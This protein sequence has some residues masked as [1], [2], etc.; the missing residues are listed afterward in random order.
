MV[1]SI[2]GSIEKDAEGVTDHSPG[3]RSGIA[4]P[5]HPFPEA[6]DIINASGDVE[7]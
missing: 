6:M 2:H 1:G 4:E 7:G 3:Q 5:I